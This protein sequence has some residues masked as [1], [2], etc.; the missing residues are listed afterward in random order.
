MK[1]LKTLARR[2]IPPSVQKEMNTKDEIEKIGLTSDNAVIIGSGILSALD[3]RESKDVD[4]V[5]TEEKYKELSIS[6]RFKKSEKHGREVLTNELFEIGTSW[7]VVG[8]VWKFD[9]LLKHSTIIDNVRYNSIKFLLEA[10]KSWLANGDVRQKDI[11]DVR[12]ME[13]Y[14]AKVR[15]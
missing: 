7:T 11:D 3:L 6:N 13:Q 9:D 15:S 4:V 10:K 14:L 5:A 8:R 12:L 2:E 1:R